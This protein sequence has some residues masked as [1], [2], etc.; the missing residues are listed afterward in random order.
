MN[1]QKTVLIVE[2]EK[3]I[4]DILRFNLQREGYETRE[5]YDGED[6]LAQA[7]SVNPDL[8]LLDVMLPKMNGFDV[9]RRLRE[10]GDNVPVIILTAREEEADKVLGLEI[11]ADDY[12][13]KPFS[14]RELI[15]RVGANIRRTSMAAAPASAAASAMPVSGDLAINTD[16]HQVFRAGKAI[17]LTTREYELL[18]FLASHPNKVYSRIDLME[19]VWNYGYVG[20]DVRTVDVTVRRL[21]EKI[22]A[23]P[24]NPVFILTRRGAGYYFSAT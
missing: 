12:I 4:V 1:T 20:D 10:K 22:E 19:Q 16:S 3:N 6:G 23:D 7:L 9:C 14:M 5:A 18:T 15:A 2:D 24:A 13:T 8:I 21:R 11:G 17:D